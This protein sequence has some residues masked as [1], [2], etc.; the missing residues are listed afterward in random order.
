M[1]V[2]PRIPIA[3]QEFLDT[4][5]RMT[6]LTDVFTRDRSRRWRA[7]S[8]YEDGLHR[9]MAI[10]EGSVDRGLPATRPRLPVVVG[11]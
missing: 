8:A 9:L 6:R 10:V 7:A 5:T 11:A 2:W 1:R 3:S 4:F